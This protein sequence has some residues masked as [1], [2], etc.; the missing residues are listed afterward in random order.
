M[1]LD[2]VYRAGDQSR[3]ASSKP[4][5]EMQK[6]P[7]TDQ[8]WEL[9]TGMRHG[10]AGLNCWTKSADRKAQ[11]QEVGLHHHVHQVPWV[12]CFTGPWVAEAAR[13]HCRNSSIYSHCHT[14]HQFDL[15]HAD[16]PE[17]SCRLLILGSGNI[18]RIPSKIPK[19][20]FVIYHR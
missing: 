10:V 8:S 20:N 9:V 19:I 7:S 16:Y 5:A 17:F 18:C 14:C 13:L 3:L 2:P 1:Q 12:F 11:Q 6:S 15:V 4:F